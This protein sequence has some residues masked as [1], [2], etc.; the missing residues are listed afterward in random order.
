MRTPIPA[1][2]SPESL[3][4]VVDSREQMPLDLAP[5]PTVVDGLRV[6]DYSVRGL[7]S[8][9]AV[10]R[11]SLDD[12][13]ACC[14][15][16]RERFQR[17]LDALRGWPVSAV[18]VESTWRAIELGQWRSKLKPR[19]VQASLTSWIAQGH[20]IILAHDHTTAGLIVRDILFFA[21]RYRWREA[22]AMVQTILD[23]Q[24]ATT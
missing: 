14:G 13:V 18:V 19:Q 7:E 17:E 3:L 11:K 23:P 22:R 15:T 10:E 8:H 5:M 16:E 24:E 1:D 21:A 6:G 9:I 2:L 4:C 20:R 12:L